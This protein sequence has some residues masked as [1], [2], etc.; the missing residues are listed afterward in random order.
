MTT[1]S[2]TIDS[3]RIDKWLWAARF[4][5]TRGLAKQ[6][7]E[8][9]HI[10]INDQR[11]KPAREAVSGDRIHIVREHEEYDIVVLAVSSIRGPAPQ[12]RLLYAETEASISQRAAEN[13]KRAA[14][15]FMELQPGPRPTKRDRRDLQ[16]WREK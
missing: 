15:R 1:D 9:G 16:R 6:A 7:I 10:R 14:N 11:C 8:A 2:D 13:A 4:F 12:A 3:V 5:K